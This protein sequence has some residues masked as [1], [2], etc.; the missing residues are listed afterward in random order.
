MVYNL[1]CYNYAS[2]E[3]KRRCGSSRCGPYSELKVSI[4]G[5]AQRCRTLV[6]D[7]A[8]THSVLMQQCGWSTGMRAFRLLLDYTR[9]QVS[10]WMRE[11]AINMKRSI[12][13]IIPQSC[14]RLFCE[15][16]DSRNCTY[17]PAS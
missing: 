11:T 10:T 1:P 17:I 5:F 6:C 13:Q 3:L 15:R 2:S 8:C 4:L 9:T 14:S 16:F 12:S 7:L